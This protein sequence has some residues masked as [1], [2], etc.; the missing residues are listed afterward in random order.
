MAP[1]IP[2]YG[3]GVMVYTGFGGGEKQSKTARM[4]SFGRDHRATLLLRGKIMMEEA[5][6]LFFIFWKIY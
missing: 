6:N 2:Y 3:S 5:P 4:P 1:S